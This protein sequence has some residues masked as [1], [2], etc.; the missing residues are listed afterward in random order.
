MYELTG[1]RMTFVPWTGKIIPKEGLLLYDG[2]L[3]VFVMYL[4][5]CDQMF[6]A[7]LSDQDSET[8]RYLVVATNKRELRKFKRGTITFTD[9]LNK[10]LFFVFD[11]AS[12]FAIKNVTLTSLESIPEDKR[13]TENTTL[14][15]QGANNG[16]NLAKGF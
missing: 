13:P 1:S 12:D 10:E 15:P 7:V 8:Y 14:Y 3:A 4:Q 16:V 6:L 2:Y 11:T 9:I 5:D